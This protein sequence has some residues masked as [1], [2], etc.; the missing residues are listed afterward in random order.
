[1]NSNEYTY[2][3]RQF[4][5]GEKMIDIYWAAPLHRKEDTDFNM[6]LVEDLRQKGYT[7]FLPQEIG[8]TNSEIDDSSTDTPSFYCRADTQA[9]F[10]CKCVC[11]AL[12]NR[13][14]S[15]GQLI[16][17]GMALGLNKPVIFYQKG[18]QSLSLILRYNCIIFQDWEACKN[19]IDCLFYGS[20]M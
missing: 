18:F 15:Q 4:N 11:A 5:G 9:V 2:T 17:I 13:E 16:E 1:M 6:E 14:P 8:V 12:N 19:Y 7:V 20:N 10:S 3:Y